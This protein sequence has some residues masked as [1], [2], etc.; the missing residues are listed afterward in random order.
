V[1]FSEPSSLALESAI[2]YARK[3][4]ASLT[5][6]TV[7]QPIRI[8]SARLLNAGLSEESENQR[9]HKEVEEKLRK[10]LAKFKLEGIEVHKEVVIGVP[11]EEII[12]QSHRASIIYMGSTGKTGLRRSV[13]GSVTERVIR[14][15]ECNVAVVKSEDLFKL[16]IPTELEDIEKHL[17]QGQE[18]VKLGFMDEAI[19]QYLMCL[20]INDMNLPSLRALAAIYEKKGN[21]E[22][23]KYYADLARV[24]SEKMTNLKIEEEIRRNLRSVK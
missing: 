15:A 13:L 11:H 22:K 21:E 8:T 14:E 2:L 4:H 12:W 18:L 3:T 23:Q 20:R 19:S 17:R 6:M 5:V 16:R 24:I 1:D 10:Y 9:R 7:I